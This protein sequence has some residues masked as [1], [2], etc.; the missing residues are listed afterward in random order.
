MGTNA[1]DWKSVAANALRLPDDKLLQILKLLDGVAG[2]PGVPEAIAQLRPRLAA[3]RPPRPLSAMRLAFLPA[4]DL[5]D[6]VDHYRRNIARISRGV[7][8]RCWEIMVNG[9]GQARITTLQGQL[10]RLTT[11]DTEAL[12]EQ[13]D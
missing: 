7:L 5:L 9:V 1:T 6:D 11:A 3:L 8:P 10:A 2:S 13:G 4:E 12:M